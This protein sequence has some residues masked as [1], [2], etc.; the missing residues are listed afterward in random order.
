M[1]KSNFENV[2]FILSDVPDSMKFICHD[3]NVFSNL[4]ELA[5][6][7][8]E[9]DEDVFLFHVNSDKN[10]FSTWIYDCLGDVELAKNLRDVND[11]KTMTKKIKI[12]I[13]YLKKKEKEND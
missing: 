12:R 13:L 8:K 7:L 5:D 6:G 2:A 3:G 9:M 1:P 11:A 10:D 4:I